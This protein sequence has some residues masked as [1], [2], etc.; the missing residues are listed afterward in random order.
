MINPTMMNAVLAGLLSAASLTALA[1]PP[2]KHSAISTEQTSSPLFSTHPT[3]AN[4]KDDAGRPKGKNA[5]EPRQTSPS[6]A[7]PENDGSP[8]V[9]NEYDVD[10]SE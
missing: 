9:D 2:R 10:T 3:P 4:N 1:D 6:S 8:G 7:Q 5:D